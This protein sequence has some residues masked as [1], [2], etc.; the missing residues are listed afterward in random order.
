MARRNRNRNRNRNSAAVTVPISKFTAHTPG[1][2]YVHFNNGNR[3][4]TSEFG[5]VRIKL[6][7]HI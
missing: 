4:A 5:V 7:R 2:E 1:L 3:K 6:A